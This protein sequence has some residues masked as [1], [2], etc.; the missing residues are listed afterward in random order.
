MT[1]ATAFPFRGLRGAGF[2][3]LELL[4]AIAVAALLLTAVPPMLSRGYDAM[5]YR[6]AVRELMAGLKG[7]RRAAMETGRSVAFVVDTAARRFG[8]EDALNG[9]LPAAL[10]VRLI[11][12]DREIDSAERGAIRFYPD[13]GATGG[14]IQLLRPGGSGVRLRVDWLLG[15]V[16]QEAPEP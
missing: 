10:Q 9:E 13:G 11:V 14:S 16:S 4:V 7:A 2:T 1:A 3:L 6:T 8:T 15:T 5:A 12:A